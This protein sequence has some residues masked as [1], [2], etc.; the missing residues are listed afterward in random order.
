M[1]IDLSEK[2]VLITGVG[3]GIGTVLLEHFIGKPKF[4][5]SSSRTEDVGI[6]NPELH[7]F[8]HFSLDLTV[9]KNV[10]KL[11]SEIYTEF[12][13]LDIVINTIGGSLYSNKLEDFSLEEFNKVI[14]VN[15]ASAFLI[16]REAT[17]I[18]KKSSTGGNI[19]HFVSSSA[20]KIS[21]NKAPYGIAKAG[22]I[23][24]INYA[25]AEIAEYNIKING[26]SPTYLFTQRHESEI[27]K[28]VQDTGQTRKEV[29]DKILDSQLIKKES[30]PFLL[31]PLLEVLMTTVSITGQVMNC[32]MGE[33]LDF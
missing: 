31:V 16:T 8:K 23:R 7:N 27:S 20:K 30:F 29:V 14:Q 19:V 15:L 11:F 6:T 32:S 4:F 3:G 10:E 22:L 13:G 25:A 18:M 21:R 28:K 12:G 5:I 2:I 17:K 9:E 1:L 26:I 24:L 33:V